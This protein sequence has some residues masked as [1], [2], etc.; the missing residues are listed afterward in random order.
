MSKRGTCKS[1]ARKEGRAGGEE[2]G[3]NEERKLCLTV[4]YN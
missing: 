4:G 2:G 1:A 3:K